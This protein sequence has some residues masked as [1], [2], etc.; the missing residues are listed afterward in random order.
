MIQGVISFS[1]KLRSA[2]TVAWLCSLF[3]TTLAGSAQ[4]LT[5]V[6]TTLDV[7]G[8]PS[9]IE[10]AD[11]NN[12]GKPDLICN[13]GGIT[14]LTN[15]GCGRFGVSVTVGSSIA[16]LA[17]ADV[18]G[19]GKPDLAGGAWDGTLTVWTNNGH[20]SFGSNAVYNIG[21]WPT[22]IAAA[23]V[24]GDDRLDL[25]VAGWYIPLLTV[26]TNHGRGVFGLNAT[27]N[28]GSYL[29]SVVAV[30]VNGNG[31]PALVSANNLSNTLSLLTN[32]GSGGFS[33]GA[34]LTVGLRPMCVAAADLDADGR[35]DIV[36]ANEDGTL[37]VLT[38]NGSG[39]FGARATLAIGSTTSQC[40]V[41]ADANGDGKPDL[42]CA[43]YEQN[44]SLEHI[45]TLMVFTNR[46][47]GVFGS[48]ATFNVGGYTSCVAAAD[49]NGDGMLDFISGRPG[50]LT[51]LT[52][53]ILGPP[54][55]TATTTGSN[56]LTLSWSSFSTNFVLQ[57]NADLASTNWVS[58]DYPVFIVNGT[59]QSAC[60]P[61]PAAGN[62]FFRLKR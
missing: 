7:G 41:A 19:D 8:S 17:V 56:T 2:S 14:V 22:C 42:I 25:I 59:N 46:G 39:S 57:T 52:Q 3:A 1:R 38:N 53:I 29:M 26:L 32:N 15:D 24:N 37:S 51:V 5:F 33:L 28:V 40:V 48:N 13:A 18:N 47:G 12:D 62:L 10:V 44:E 30:D 49:I 45:G 21:G 50:A 27:Y 6:M 55:L 35:P 31:K 60:I 43:N 9:R 34:M 23:D 36:S 11:V 58:A 4:G 61:Q 20:G 16:C 54:M